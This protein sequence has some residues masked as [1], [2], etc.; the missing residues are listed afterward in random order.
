MKTSKINVAREPP[1]KFKS[2][3]IENVEVMYGRVG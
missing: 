2:K 1:A 3:R